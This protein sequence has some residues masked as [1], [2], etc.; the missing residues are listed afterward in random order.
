MEGVATAC[1]ACGSSEIQ[2]AEVA[3]E[4]GRVE[5]VPPPVPRRAATHTGRFYGFGLLGLVVWTLAAI[6]VCSFVA[7]RAE[8][9]VLV[10]AVAVVGGLMQIVRLFTGSP[11]PTADQISALE[12]WKTAHREWQRTRLC[13]RCGMSFVPP[14]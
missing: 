12:E 9:V 2:G 14:D 11:K 8:S 4:S 13:L 3:W 5:S 6:Y 7:A 10:A 1:P